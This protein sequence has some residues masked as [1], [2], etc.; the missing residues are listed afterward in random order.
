MFVAREKE[1]NL[2][3]EFL[4]SKGALLVYGLRR[5][6]K[7]TLI[8]K[9]AQ[10]SNKPFVYFECQKADEDKNVLLLVDLLKEQVGFVDAQFNSFL[11]V[12]KEFNRLYPGYILIIDEYSL[13]KQYYFQ[14]RKPGYDEKAE[15]L[16]SEFQNI[17]DQH[18]D[19]INLIIS[20]SSLHIMKQLTEHR[21]PLYG[22]FTREIALSQFNYLDAKK[23]MPTLS[24]YDA[25][26]YY[27]VFGGSPYVLERLDTSKS[28]KD[29]ICELILDENGK[30]RTHLRNNVINELENDTDLHDILDVIKNGSKKYSDIVNKAHITTS[31]LLDKRLNKLLELDIIEAKFPIGREEDR[32]K[33][34]YQIKDNL[35]KFYYAYV[36]RQ[37]NRISL[38]SPSRYYDLYIEPSLKEFISRRFENIVRDYFTVGFSKGMFEDVIDIG[39]FFTSDNEYDCVLKKKNGKYAIYEVKYH[40]EPMTIGEQNKEIEQI[41]NIVG[42]DI[43][44]IGLVCSSGFLDEI[45]GIKYLDIEDIYFVDKKKIQDLIM[46]SYNTRLSGE[47]DYS[48]EESMKELD[49]IIKANK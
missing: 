32:R 7:T 11:Q 12:I 21:N 26:A 47:K 1:L 19:N 22:R 6:G 46:D 45:E 40:K 3:N 37:D 17:I 20:G 15:E 31:G 23:M 28:L 38:L 39:S 5:V 16:D 9:A 27:S 33:K 43:D 42:L 25:V 34:Y 44:E 35:L 49:K 30:L 14:S 13:M 4:K 29:N 24:I 8:Q 18:I 36:F 48:L 10:D 41:K 2:I